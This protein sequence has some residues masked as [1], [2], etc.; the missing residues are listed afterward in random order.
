MKTIPAVILSL[1][2]DPV[3]SALVYHREAIETESSETEWRGLTPAIDGESLWDGQW[4]G[5]QRDG[6]CVHLSTSVP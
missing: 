2:K 6:R 5:E 4:H 1:A 3:D